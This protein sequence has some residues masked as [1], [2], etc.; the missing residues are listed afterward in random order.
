MTLTSVTIRD[1]RATP[2]FSPCDG[3]GVY[4]R[5]ILSA[6]RIVLAGN[7]TGGGCGGK[8]A[9]IWNGG[10][11]TFKDSTVSGNSAS[12]NGGGIWNT[13]TFMLSN[14]TVSSNAGV[15]ASGGIWNAGSIT[16]QNGTIAGNSGGIL[17]SGSGTTTLKSTLLAG[18]TTGEATDCAGTLN[19]Q[20]HNLV[21]NTVGCTISGDLT[22][23]ITGQ[24]PN[25]APLQDN[26][27]PAET[28]ALLAGSPAIDAG[29][30]DCPPPDSDQR[31]IPR[32]MGAACDIGAFELEPP[33]VPVRGVVPIPGES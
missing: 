16:S 3:G 18:N 14:S 15:A 30:S 1:N 12:E 20:G 23:N 24:N 22:G 9:G 25:L 21:Q 17:N 7:V 13:G 32:P 2:F 6:E 4:N 29:G 5:G 19:S 28:H 33:P 31:G 10:T 11:A 8:G 27:G 26:G